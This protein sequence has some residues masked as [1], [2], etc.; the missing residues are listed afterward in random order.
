MLCDRNVNNL[1]ATQTWKRH[2]Y[3]N[4]KVT[5]VSLTDSDDVATGNDNK[6]D[7]LDK[8][9][10]AENKDE[11]EIPSLESSVSQL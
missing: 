10:P 3:T 1:D 8:E 6:N 4:C 9:T 7:E 11:S 5:N 2:T